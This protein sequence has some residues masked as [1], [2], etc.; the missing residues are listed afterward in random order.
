MKN[1]WRHPATITGDAA[2]DERYI[3]RNH[4]NDAFWREVEKGNHILFVAPRRVGKTSIM[5]DLAINCPDGFACIYQNIEGV[6]SKNEFYQRLLDLIEECF[7]KSKFKE[8]RDAIADLFKKFKFKEISTSGI[9]VER[10]DLDYEKELRLLIPELKKAKVHTV[11]FLDEFAEVIYK[12]HRKGSKEDAIEILHFLRELRS[13]GD[14]KHFTLV[15]AGSIGLEFVIRTIDRPKLINDLHPIVTGPLTKNEASQLIRQLTRDATIRLSKS[16]IEYLIDKVHY[17]LP[18]HIQLMLEEIDWLAFQNKSSLITP[19]I[20]DEAFQRVVDNRGRFEDWLERLKNYHA[21]PFP[22]INDI[23]KYAAHNG[24]I[25]LQQVYN[26]AAD[27]RFGRTD[28]YMKF[29]DMLRQ[30]GY[31]IENPSHVYSFI[32]PFLQQFWLK[33]YPIY[34]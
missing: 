9:T 29:L 17:L 24:S 18:Y 2:T 26:K 15:F 20:V 28:D 3:R 22:F 33:Q 8:A 11:I 10:S 12:L 7:T 6:R 14:F 31:F 16:L 4:I 30:E 34:E 19:Q 32:S 5:M 23:L 25:T 13:A 27:E 21:D 1:K